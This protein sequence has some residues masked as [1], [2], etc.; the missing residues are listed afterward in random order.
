[1]IKIN[2]TDAI[3]LLKKGKKI[4]R[5]YYIKNAYL[6]QDPNGDF[7]ERHTNGRVVMAGM[8]LL[9]FNAT[10]WEEYKEEDNWSW[11]SSEGSGDMLGSDYPARA[12]VKKLQSKL[13]E[14]ISELKYQGVQGL[15]KEDL[16]KEIINQRFG[17][18]EQK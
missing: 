2:F 18:G 7:I 13:L 16:V 14:D 9:E 15:I 8:N 11:E 5:K 10:D 12:R 1:M 4:R 6:C 3:G 17:F